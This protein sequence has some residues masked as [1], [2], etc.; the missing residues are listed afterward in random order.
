MRMTNNL[1]VLAKDA[2]KGNAIQKVAQAAMASPAVKQA[3]IRALNQRIK[4]KHTR[5]RRVRI[6]TALPLPPWYGGHSA[7]ASTAPYMEIE[8]FERDTE[9]HS[10]SSNFFEGE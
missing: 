3:L 1:P 7:E 2:T 4:S 10:A 6:R 9:E 8:I 5:T